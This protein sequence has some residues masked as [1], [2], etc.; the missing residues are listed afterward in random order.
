MLVP[1]EIAWMCTAM[2]FYVMMTIFLALWIKDKPASASSS[3][4][5]KKKAQSTAA[6]S[7]INHIAALGPLGIPTK[8]TFEDRRKTTAAQP[9]HSISRG[10]PNLSHA[11]DVTLTMPPPRSTFDDPA[12]GGADGASVASTV[13]GSAG[14][15][16]ISEIQQLANMDARQLASVLA[17]DP[18]MSYGNAPARPTGPPLQAFPQKPW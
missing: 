1:G 13:P 10:S 9:A 16:T 15:S 14:V 7:S 6:P 5:N 11:S 8:G 3:G 2:V 18:G 4:S 17:N 12:P